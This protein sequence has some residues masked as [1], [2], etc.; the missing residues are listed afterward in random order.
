MK[1]KR[2]VVGRRVWKIMVEDSPEY[3]LWIVYGPKLKTSHIVLP[4]VHC[5]CYDFLFNVLIRGR[6]TKCYHILA[7][8]I[9]ESQGKYQVVTMDR[10]TLT[11][12]IFLQKLKGN[13]NVWAFKAR[14]QLQL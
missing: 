9:A 8:E 5:D 1:A 6:K 12:F 14:Q 11:K 3:S 13:I 10:A 4:G 2:A 7:Q